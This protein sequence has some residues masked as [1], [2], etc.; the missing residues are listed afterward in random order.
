MLHHTVGYYHVESS[1][2]LVSVANPIL[3]S[4]PVLSSHLSVMKVS[5]CKAIDVVSADLMDVGTYQNM[6]IPN[7]YVSLAFILPVHAFICVINLSCKSLF[8]SFPNK[9]NEHLLSTAHAVLCHH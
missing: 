4:H 5:S 7:V 8:L 9:K 6:D 3:C 2:H 1:R